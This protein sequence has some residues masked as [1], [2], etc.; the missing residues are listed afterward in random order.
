MDLNL[1]KQEATST[2]PHRFPRHAER[3]SGF[4]AGGSVFLP[5]CSLPEAEGLPTI[6]R[7]SPDAEPP[8][9]GA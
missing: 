7:T 2:R 9:C 6:T 5:A 4:G 3:L 1:R 8:A